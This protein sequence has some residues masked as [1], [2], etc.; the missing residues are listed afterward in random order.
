[1]LKAI[2]IEDEINNREALEL[3]IKRYCPGVKL[4]DTCA[5]GKEGLWAIQ[6]Y[7]PDL[8]FL[9]IEMPGMNAFQML[10]E[11]EDIP[12]SIIFTT[13]H[14]QYA[15]KAFEFSA[16]DY[17][18]KPIDPEELQRAVEK[19][20]EQRQSARMSQEQ[21]SLLQ[22]NYF[23]QQLKRMAIPAMGK[24]H[25]I[26]IEEIIYCEADGPTTRIFLSDGRQIVAGKNLR[27]IEKYLHN[28]PFYR[29]HNSYLI[30]LNHILEY[31]KGD[32]YVL[33]QNGQQLSVAHSKSASF[34]QE[35]KKMSI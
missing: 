25:F 10:E 30:N 13:A 19:A 23:G 8:V 6:K 15:I 26:L 18:L 1:M 20:V 35:I 22:E 27:M 33:M 4:I 5:S 7:Q 11:L 32:K 28:H 21:L 29:I 34:V 17:L 16:V 2:I 9:D 12:F 14:S 24:Y 31:H 3:D